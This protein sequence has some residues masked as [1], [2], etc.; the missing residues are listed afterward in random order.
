V[1]PGLLQ[2]PPISAEES[3]YPSRVTSGYIHL[4]FCSGLC[5]FCSYFVVVSQAPES[6]ERIAE[7]VDHL[8]L[9]VDL[10][11]ERTEIELAYLYFGGGTPSLLGPRAMIRLLEGL[12]RRGALASEVLATVELHPEFFADRGSADEFL[13]VLQA[14]GINRVSVGFQGA[15]DALLDATNRRHRSGFAGEAVEHVRS[16]GFQVNLD[17][18]YGLPGQSM[19]S[20][21][22]SLEAAIELGGDSV[23]TYFTFIDPGTVLWRDVQRGAV[24]LPSH[25]LLQTQHLAAQLALEEAGYFELPGDFWSRP[26]GD[27]AGFAQTSL[28]SQG[29]S[30]GLGAGAYGYYSGMQYFNH[31]TLRG[32]GDSLRERRIPLWRGAVLSGEQQLC[33]DTMFSLKNSPSLALDLFV[34][35]HGL[36]P[37][38]AYEGVFDLLLEDDLIEV[39]P[40]EAR[41][42]PKGRLLVEEIACLFEPHGHHAG[43]QAHGRDRT[44]LRR[45][46]FAPTYSASAQH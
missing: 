9:E 22:S 15:D 18:M 39:D 7:Y 3:P 34:D 12:D 21:M 17:L 19:E 23:S 28:P 30:L 43:T 5:H 16:R 36:S 2:L 14:Y 10:N 46:N 44:R 27:P 20:W 24:A 37:V 31:F 11:L 33:R 29:N 13:D 45:H 38:E 4:P 32:Y 1:W 6:D 26:V 41:L 25:E 8:L 42:T 40:R 35:R